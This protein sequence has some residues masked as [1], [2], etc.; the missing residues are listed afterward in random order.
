MV[1]GGAQ[2]ELVYPQGV[3]ALRKSDAIFRYPSGLLA[4]WW[5][6]P[7]VKSSE[8]S[9]SDAFTMRPLL[10]ISDNTQ[11]A[12]VKQYL[13]IGVNRILSALDAVN[14]GDIFIPGVEANQILSLVNPKTGQPYLIACGSAARIQK[15]AELLTQLFQEE[16]NKKAASTDP[17]LQAAQPSSPSS[18]PAPRSPVVSP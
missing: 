18:A 5:S 15:I 1:I 8:F 2:L 13:P 4:L 16:G 9:M 6:L 10:S 11:G 3:F 12:P 7:P 14:E 17:L